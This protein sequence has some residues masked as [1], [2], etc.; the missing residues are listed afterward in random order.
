M[1]LPTA[2]KAEKKVEEEEEEG[3]DSDGP[4]EE[5]QHEFSWYLKP[6]NTFQIITKRWVSMTLITMLIYIYHLIMAIYGVDQYTDI[7]Q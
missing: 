4:K 7:S 5:P 1:E 3:S 6:E 2:D